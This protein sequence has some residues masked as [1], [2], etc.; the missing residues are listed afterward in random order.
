ME[1][2]IARLGLIRVGRY[3]VFLA[4]V[5]ESLLNEVDAQELS[6]PPTRRHR[7]PKSQQGASRGTLSELSLSQQSDSWNKAHRSK[8]GDLSRSCLEREFQEDE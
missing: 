2:T 3:A 6:Q 5:I 8:W 1:K 7:T 4:E